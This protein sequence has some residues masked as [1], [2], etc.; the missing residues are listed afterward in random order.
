MKILNSKK[1]NILEKSG[2]SIIEVIISAVIFSI[3]AAGLFATV[4]SLRIPATESQEAVTAALIGN[5]ILEELANEVD[6]GDWDKVSN[7]LYADPVNNSTTTDLAKIH[8]GD[9]L[10]GY[11]FSPKRK[12]SKD[13]DLNTGTL[14]T[15][16]RLVELTIS[17]VPGPCT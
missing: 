13:I 1:G 8:V 7:G 2:F 9:T 3:V 12:V 11:C 4:S 17:W 6:K 14:L 10:G 16:G 15:S 5:Q